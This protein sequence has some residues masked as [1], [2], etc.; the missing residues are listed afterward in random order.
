MMCGVI[1]GIEEMRMARY[2][3]EDNA[4]LSTKDLLCLLFFNGNN[5]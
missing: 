1:K 2:L 4:Y 3:N 5:K